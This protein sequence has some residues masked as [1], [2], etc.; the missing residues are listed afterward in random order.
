MSKFGDCYKV[1][2]DYV[3]DNYKVPY[4]LCHGIVAGAGKL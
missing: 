3:I 2:A 4:V 1:A